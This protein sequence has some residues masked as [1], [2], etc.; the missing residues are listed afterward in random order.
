MEN[1][2]VFFGWVKPKPKI[3]PKPPTPTVPNK[4]IEK[5]K[6]KT[7]RQMQKLPAKKII[8]VK[9]GVQT[10][11]SATTP[12]RPKIEPGIR[13]VNFRNFSY[14]INRFCTDNVKGSFAKVVNGKLITARDKDYGPQGFQVAKI[15]YGDLNG[16][17]KEEAVV[18]TLCGSLEPVQFNQSP[19]GN[20]YVYTMRSGNPELLSLFNDTDL[21]PN[22]KNY[23]REETF[24]FGG[25]AEKVLGNKLNY[26]AMVLEGMCCPKWNVEMVLR[27][28]GSRFVLDG[29]PR[30]TPWR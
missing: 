28:D 9:P 17:G 19:F 8:P 4:I 14:P 5:T 22:Y 6:P 12:V 26:G 2:G 13:S 16:D 20:T 10:K 30:R 18:S 15:I 27:W 7:K 25:G 1:V 11:K 29:K 21:E 3:L 24:L 23:F